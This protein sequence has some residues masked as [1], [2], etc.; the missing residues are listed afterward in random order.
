MQRILL[1]SPMPPL[2]GGVSKSSERLYNNLLVDGYDVDYYNLKFSN[3][4]YNNALG[5]V[6]RFFFIPFYVLFHKKYDIIHCHVPGVLRKVYISL[7]TCFYKRAKLIFTIHGDITGLLKSRWAMKA[8]EKADKIICVQMGDT[9]RLPD[10]L[11]CKSV[12]IPAFIMP[13]NIEK[14][15][16]SGII[17]SFVDRDDNP[18]LLFYGAVVLRGEMFDLYGIEDTIKLYFDLRQQGEC[19]KLMM[20]IT[21]NETD[22]DQVEFLDRIKAK[23]VGEENVCVVVNPGIEMLPLFAQ[24]KV[25]LRPTKTDGDSLAVREA[26]YLGCGVVASNKSV[27]PTGTMV[28]CDYVDFVDKTKE[29]LK[30]SDIKRQ[31]DNNFYEDIRKVYES[32]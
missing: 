15:Q 2:V 3:T 27:R 4:K 12:D 11:K 19:F 14:E 6:L 30:T 17:K 9:N 29:L 7:F 24:A 13:K 25:Y 16:L 22:R 20:L 28:Y 26:L 5:I 1:V 32:L 31:Q 8:L 10:E 18:L 21:C 23:I